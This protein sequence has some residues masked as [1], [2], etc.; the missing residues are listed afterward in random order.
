MVHFLYTG[1]YQCL[2]LE[3][4]SPQDERIA[5]FA[6]S[7]RVFSMARVYRL[8]TLRYL[9]TREIQRLGDGLSLPCIVDVLQDVHSNL[10][11]EDEWL[12]TYLAS[13]TRSELNTLDRPRAEALL[14]EIGCVTTINKVLLRA[15]V[16]REL[17]QR[18][19]L[20]QKIEHADR[21][22]PAHSELMKHERKAGLARILP[23]VD[24]A[25]LEPPE[26]KPA[27]EIPA[28]VAWS[29]GEEKPAE[30][31]MPVEALWPT[32]EEK[33]VERAEDEKPASADDQFY[34]FWGLSRCAQSSDP[35]F[36]GIGV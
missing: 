6:T 14:L 15:V 21:V 18:E 33:P 29:A 22:L 20:A 2:K 30:D 7:V 11:D 25:E 10:C 24:Y 9:A 5:E 32:E 34:A 23:S 28:E 12:E 26:E 4:Q 3:G 8:P 35:A 17:E 1:T 27:E 36:G 16:G 19:T 13:R 31:E